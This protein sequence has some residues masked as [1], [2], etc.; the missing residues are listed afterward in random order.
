MTVLAGVRGGKGNLD[1]VGAAARLAFPSG[2]ALDSAG[3]VYVADTDNNA[4]RKISPDGVVTTL[5]GYVD[6]PFGVAVDGAGNVYVTATFNHA[7]FKISPA[8]NQTVFAGAISTRGSV[9]GAGSDARFDSPSGLA[10]DKDGNLYVADTGN[11]L[12]R[13]ITPD[14]LV[15]SLPGLATNRPYGVAVD[16]SGNVYVAN[17]GSHTIREFHADTF[18][19]ETIAGQDGTWGSTDGDRSH[20]K[21][22]NPIGIALDRAGNIYV[23]DQSNHTIRKIGT[24]GQVST[25]AGMAGEQGSTDGVHDAARFS[26]PIGIASDSRGTVYVGDVGNGTIRKITPEGLVFTLAGAAAVTGSTDGPLA[27]ARFKDPWG[28]VSDHSGNIYVADSDNL[29]LRKINAAG[30]VSTLA[31]VAGSGGSTDGTGSAA[32]F[33]YL[34]GV[35]TDRSGNV[36]LCD[37]GNQTI[38]KITPSGMV[39]TLAGTAGVGGSQDGQ[40]AAASF[41]TL[42]N[43]AVDPAGNVFVTDMGNHTIRKITPAGLVSTFAGTTGVIGSSDGRSAAASF[44]SPDGIAADSAGN[45]YV[46]DTY[47]HTIRKV[48]P[49][50]MVS[51]LAG[52]AGPSYFRVDGQ[53][54]AARFRYPGALAV[55]SA[56][57]VFVLDTGNFALRK[58]TPSGVVTTLAVD[59][60]GA[61]GI[62][63]VGQNVLVTIEGAILSVAINP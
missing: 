38:R 3:N 58:V 37:A 10:M 25:L 48:T 28:I 54:S 50:G 18:W 52:K 6:H 19:F 9:N 44:N 56:D 13:K 63:V 14:G 2:V 16:A 20:A 42:R 32:R 39:T 59:L 8:G 45:L 43:V 17:T 22:S 31:G 61:K 33:A 30:V 11:N 49:D 23:S 41:Q 29:T 1:G 60:Y 62:T 53:G 34:M 35:A 47:N 46:A 27:L 24:D 21:F 5:G 40:G 26:Y 15:G 4:I 57:N 55:D 12:V 7:I 36:Y 51:T